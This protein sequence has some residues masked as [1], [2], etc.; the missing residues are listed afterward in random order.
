MAD[1]AVFVDAVGRVLGSARD[2]LGPGVSGDS[3]SSR[4]MSAAD[5]SGSGRAATAAMDA[6]TA[7]AQRNSALAAADARVVSAANAAADAHRGHVMRL[8]RVIKAAGDDVS[9]LG[10]AARTS[11]SGQRALVDALTQRLADGKSAYEDAIRDG[12]T[13]AGNVRAATDKFRELLGAEGTKPAALAGT[14]PAA[15]TRALGGLGNIGSTGAAL[16]P[17][18]GL[19]SS[20]IPAV[21]GIAPAV[22]GVPATILKAPLDMVGPIFSSLGGVGQSLTGSV[23]P[24]NVA[25]ATGMAAP[26][27]YG[28][29]AASGDETRDAIVRRGLTNVGKP[30]VFGANGPNAW[31]CSSVVQDAYKGAGISVP[32]TTYGWMNLGRVVGY[33]E[34]KAGDVLLTNWKNGRAEH[35]MMAISS[36]KVLEAPSSGQLVKVRAV[37]MSGVGQDRVVIRRILPD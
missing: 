17:M 16:G 23:G 10:P 18:G 25:A 7:L 35:M 15:A 6:H 8:D 11:P 37:P 26:G 20:V 24:Q 9:A 28:P 5:G 32:R 33:G 29:L 2:S 3:W 36:D 13:H 22:L 19:A 1:L 21:G 27:E 4:S 12:K 14:A 34:L 31:D 30:Y